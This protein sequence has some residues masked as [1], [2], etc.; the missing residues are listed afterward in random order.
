MKGGTELD[1]RNGSEWGLRSTPT[2]EQ[3]NPSPIQGRVGEEVEIGIQEDEPLT[4]TM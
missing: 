2:T 4:Y 1:G 3:G